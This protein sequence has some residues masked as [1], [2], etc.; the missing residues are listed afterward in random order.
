MSYIS[1]Y[2][3][4]SM[5]LTSLPIFTQQWGPGIKFKHENMQKKCNLSRKTTFQA[6]FMTAWCIFFYQSV[7]FLP[8]IM[9]FIMFFITTLCFYD[10][11]KTVLVKKCTPCQVRIL[12]SLP[13]AITITLVLMWYFNYT[14]K[15]VLSLRTT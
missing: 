7:H 1:W 8:I 13:N 3:S 14:I 4:E 9:M 5:S 12:F 6:H 15:A 2:V 10:F 11:C